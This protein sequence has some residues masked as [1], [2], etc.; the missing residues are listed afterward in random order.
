MI[1]TGAYTVKNL[2]EDTYKEYQTVKDYF[3]YEENMVEYSADVY[4]V[5]SGSPVRFGSVNRFVCIGLTQEPNDTSKQP[6]RSRDWLP[7]SQGPV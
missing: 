1:I 7:A 6:I 3:T 2:D 4:A 5:D